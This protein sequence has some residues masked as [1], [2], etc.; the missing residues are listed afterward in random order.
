M[1]QSTIKILIYIVVFIFS[2]LFALIPTV[3]YQIGKRAE[4]SID[5]KRDKWRENWSHKKT[6]FDYNKIQNFLTKNGA[7]HHYQVI[8]DPINFIEV[9]FAV[10]FLLATIVGVFQ[11]MLIVPAFMLGL[12]I[13]T[14]LIIATNSG[15]NN[16]MLFDIS[17]I[18]NALHTQIEAGVY[19]D[20]AIRECYSVVKNK[21]L[22]AEMLVMTGNL[23]RSDLD[24]EQTIDTFR[25]SFNN[26]QIEALSMILKQAKKSGKAIAALQ[27]ILEQIKEVEESALFLQKEKMTI[28]SQLIELSFFAGTVTLVIVY[29]MKF[30]YQTILGF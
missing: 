2:A 13:P 25:G 19:P 16:D 17:L 3:L 29:S 23:E 1:N 14:I 27:D 5:T 7:K 21:R 20:N 11:L 8:S 10:G 18:F 12:A 15:D 9:S 24:F 22:R 6:L 28:R 30:V 4:K 26:S